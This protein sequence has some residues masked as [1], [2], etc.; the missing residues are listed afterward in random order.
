[1][2][3]KTAWK[4][5]ENSEPQCSHLAGDKVSQCQTPVQQGMMTRLGKLCYYQCPNIDCRNIRDDLNL[6]TVDNDFTVEQV[7]VCMFDYVSAM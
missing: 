4:L 5:A 6:I 3:L 2:T 7:F 1:M